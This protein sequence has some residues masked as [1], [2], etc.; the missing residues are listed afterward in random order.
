SDIPNNRIMRWEEETGVLSVFRKASNVANG[1]ARDRQGRLVT[2]LHGGRSVIRTEI[3]GSIRVV[4]DRYD[5]KRLN[6]PNDVVVK[7]DG[8]IW[9]SDPPFGLFGNYE[10]YK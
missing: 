3:D 5:G 4:A 10:G 8:S 9:F 2:C 1:N 6:S 7:S